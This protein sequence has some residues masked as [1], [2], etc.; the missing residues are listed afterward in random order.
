MGL[1][2]SDH[3]DALEEISDKASK[4]HS[5]YAAMAKM[6]QDWEPLEFTCI[7]V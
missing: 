2:I 4:E 3:N 5:N 6:K 1:N 7:E